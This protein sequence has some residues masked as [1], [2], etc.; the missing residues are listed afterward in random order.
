MVK[1]TTQKRHWKTLIC[2]VSENDYK[3]FRL[4]KSNHFHILNIRCKLSTEDIG[5]I[6]KKPEA[7]ILKRI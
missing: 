1:L 4:E 2:V 3:Q 6:L 5:V 7:E